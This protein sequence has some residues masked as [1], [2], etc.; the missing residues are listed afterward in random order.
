MGEKLP[1]RLVQEWNHARN[2]IDV[3][4][5]KSMSHKKVWWICEIG[6]EWEAAVYSRSNGG[7]CPVCANRTILKGFNDLMTTDPQLAETWHPTRNGNLSPTMVSRSSAR[8]VW[9]ICEK[10]HEWETVINS[11]TNSST[12]CPICSNRIIRVGINDLA[13][14]HPEMAKEWHPANNDFLTAEMVAAGSSKKIWWLGGCAHEWVA[15]LVKRSRGSNCPVCS[16]K[17]VLSGYNDLLTKNPRLAAEWH[18]TKNSDFHP[19]DV[20]EQS[21]KK[22][23]WLG[24]C[25]HEWESQIS[26]RSKNNTGCPI[27]SGRK[28]LEGFNDILTTHPRLK[29]FWDA[30]LNAAENNLLPSKGS[31]NKVF[32]KCS[33]NHSW[34]TSANALIA[35]ARCPVCSGHKCVAGVNDL[36]T[37]H[38]DLAKEWHPTKNGN[39]DPTEIIAGSEYKAWWQCS[40]GHEWKSRVATRKYNSSSCPT[41]WASDRISKSEKEVLDFLIG[42]GFIVEHSNRQILDNR[43]E[44]DFYLPEKKIGIEFNGLYWHSEA[45]G[46]SEQYH[47]AK[48]LAAKKVGVQLIQIWED[49]WRDRKELVMRTLAHRLDAHLKLNELK[50]MDTKIGRAILY[51]TEVVSLTSNQ[52]RIFLNGNHVQ[53]FSSGSHYLG[54]RDAHGTLRS[55]MV[56]KEE[57]NRTLRI[58]QYAAFGITTGFSQMLAHAELVYKPN[59]F[60]VDANHCANE[61]ILY[62]DNSFVA[63]NEMAP[64]YMYL[65]KAE[66]KP[67]SDFGWERFHDDS[68]FYWE[69]G[70]SQPELAKLNKIHRIWDA[71][72]TRY[73][74]KNASCVSRNMV[75]S[76]KGSALPHADRNDTHEVFPTHEGSEVMSC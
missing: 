23:W 57:S 62:E 58:L 24:I 75:E 16:S 10:A 14:T 4:T 60:V 33:K 65:F 69:N 2:V 70:L 45:A 13:T 38:P 66:R 74:R 53:G 64:D 18:P 42:L 55:V 32:W 37:T 12:N 22:V 9:W 73:I 47:R 49:D 48:W 28:V 30:D 67:K 71:G 40:K 19:T 17:K 6:H 72:K 31:E 15:S 27:C 46:R 20:M 76:Q 52:A 41:C 25:G 39:T 59:Y 11:R 7:N 5:V 56:L 8:K 3:E 44:I 68:N 29:E 51:E 34:R 43:K 21:N 61:E 1:V 26:Q 35:G 63:N 54:V 36:Q 50:D